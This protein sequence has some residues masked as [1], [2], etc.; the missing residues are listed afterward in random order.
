MAVANIPHQG[1]SLACNSFDTHSRDFQGCSPR[2][3]MHPAPLGLDNLDLFQVL[4]HARSP[5][6]APQLAR[7]QTLANAT[8]YAECT[9]C[10]C[11][12]LASK[13]LSAAGLS[14]RK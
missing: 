1:A 12:A 14:V 6:H 2:K 13:R 5:R 4:S 9:I 10:L 3:E 11:H 7:Q 8:S